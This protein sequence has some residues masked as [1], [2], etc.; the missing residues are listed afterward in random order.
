M[1]N[2]KFYGDTG[3]F[4]LALLEAG[5][6][7]QATRASIFNDYRKHGQ[8]RRLKLWFATEVFD[9]PQAQQ[10]KLEKSLRELFGTRIEHM[11]FIKGGIGRTPG[12]KSLTIKLRD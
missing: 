10:R 3:L 12:W 9:A 7:W 2:G 5:F 1:A 8:F 11:E 4:R 6:K